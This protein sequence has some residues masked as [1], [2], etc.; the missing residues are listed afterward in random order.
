[1]YQRLSALLLSCLLG[2]GL[3]LAQEPAS[4]PG[5]APSEDT[6]M[7]TKE[8]AKDGTEEA[9]EDKASKAVV[10]KKAP[11]FSLK[12]TKG[13]IH[14]L[15]DY[16]GKYVVIEWF[17]PGCPYC[18][19]IYKEGIVQDTRKKMRSIDPDAVYLAINSTANQPED[20]I[21]TQSDSFLAD[22][23]QKDIPVLMDYDGTVGRLYEA[24]TTPHMYLINPDGV[25]IYAGAIT[26]DRNFTNGTES[27]NH[28]IVAA[29]QDTSGEKVAPTKVQPW[30]CGVKYADGGSRRGGNR[31]GGGRRG[32][33]KPSES[34]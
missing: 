22:H 32:G 28:V 5:L 2:G 33:G 4:D 23:E 34:P 24:K 14:N 3:A 12:D 21:V 10:G 13:K 27:T 9:T 17:N 11:A 8:P 1:M 7:P 19:G 26:D 25:L 16:S 18:R 29:R 31:R 6:P 20:F 15:S 30:G